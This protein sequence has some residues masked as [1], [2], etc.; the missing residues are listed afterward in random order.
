MPA[1]APPRGPRSG[2]V[3]WG[4]IVVAVGAG[5]LAAAAGLRI[6]FQL[7]FIALL[8]VAGVGLLVSSLI[9]AVRRRDRSAS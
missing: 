5:I 3:I 1:P 6:D 8:A 4:L 9:G 2:T 7:A